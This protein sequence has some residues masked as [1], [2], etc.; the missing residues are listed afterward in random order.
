MMK[1]W[2]WSVVVSLTILPAILLAEPGD[3]IRLDNITLSPYLGVSATRDSNVYNAPADETSDTFFDIGAGLKADYQVNDLLADGLFFFNHR[4][5]SSESDLDFSAGGEMINLNYGNRD[6]IELKIGESF[7]RA[8]DIDMVRLGGVAIGGISSDS[9]LDSSSRA[10][11]DIG[12]VAVGVGRNLSDKVDLDVGYRYDDVK[13]D[14]ASLA[15]ISGNSVSAESGVKVTDKTAGTLTAIY[16]VQKTAGAADENTSI[17]IRAGAKT[18]GTEKVT[19]KAGIGVLVYD[20][21]IGGNSDSENIASYDLQANWKATDKLGITLGGA[22]G[23]QSSSVYV[24][25]PAEF[26]MLWLSGSFAATPAAV[27]SAGVTYRQDSYLDQV[28]IAG[29]MTDR[30]DDGISGNVRVDVKP[31]GLKF[32]NLFGEALYQS[33]NSDVSD[34]DDTRIAIGANVHY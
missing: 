31:R 14:D 32:V 20:R 22:N 8:E 30:T 27:V 11:R 2:N 19:F 4:A 21:A 10:T 33:V 26:N 29:V 17:A 16:G 1:N 28:E 25:N 15:H 6:R 12:Q 34:F 9:L 7:R 18:L 23:I 24:N 13:Y 5:Y 3:G